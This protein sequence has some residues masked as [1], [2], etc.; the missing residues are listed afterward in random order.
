MYVYLEDRSIFSNIHLCIIV[1]RT[2]RSFNE[3]PCVIRE[4]LPDL[5]QKKSQQVLCVYTQCDDSVRDEHFKNKGRRK[6]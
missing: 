4:M 6:V 3:E 5:F 2:Q 1:Q